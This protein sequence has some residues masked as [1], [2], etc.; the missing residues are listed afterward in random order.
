MS[1]RNITKK[2]IKMKKPQEKEVVV[3]NSKTTLQP[4]FYVCPCCGDRYSK[5]DDYFYKSYSEFF[6]GWKHMPICKTCFE[7]KFYEFVQKYDGDEYR[8]I[9]KLCEKYDIYY[10]KK[11]FDDCLEKTSNISN[12]VG[13][14]INKVLTSSNKT[15]TYDTTLAEEK[16]ERFDFGEITV[17][18]DNSE[19]LG[20]KK[21]LVER[22]G[23][24]IFTEDDYVVLEEHYKML[25]KNNPNADNN[26]EIFIKSLCHLNLLM[27]KALKNSNLDGYTKANEQYSKTFTK[28]GLKTVEEKDSSNND[29]VGVTLAVISKYTPEEFYKDKKLFEDYDSLGEYYDRHICRPM[30]N[31]ITSSDVRDEEFFVPDDEGDDDE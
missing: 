4:N 22:W 6:A 3:V 26:Q 25:K 15:K 23:V 18:N 29:V 16:V 1:T 12:K 17:S 7:K 13:A 19:E 8:A 5:L 14:Y 21:S 28:A 9:R 31:L 2:N 27:M 30:K 10:S 20:I 24:G 11:I